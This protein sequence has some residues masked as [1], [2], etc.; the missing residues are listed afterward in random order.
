MT[1]AKW[2][3]LADKD[4]QS[5]K[6]MFDRELAEKKLKEAG[7]P[8]TMKTMQLGLDKNALKKEKPQEVTKKVTE[9]PKPKK[10]KNPYIYFLQ[11]EMSK[12][13]ESNN[14]QNPNT[15]VAAIGAKWREM[16]DEQK[17]PFIDLSK[18]DL[19]RFQKEMKEFD[20]T[21]FFTNAKGEYSKD[22]PVVKT[23]VAQNSKVK[24]SK[25]LKPEP[26]ISE[27]LEPVKPRKAMFPYLFYVKE[28]TSDTMKENKC[29]SASGAVK[30][31]SEQ[32]RKLTKEEKQPYIDK[33][34]KDQERHKKQMEEFKK[35]GQFTLE[36]GTSSQ[37]LKPKKKLGKL[38]KRSNKDRQNPDNEEEP[39]NQKVAKK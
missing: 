10:A 31:L 36:D 35:T 22:S 12:F 1:L 2:N 7:P 8:K 18:K 14:G 29:A 38:G 15:F 5:F 17:A 20:S 21:G 4:K 19:E 30:I 32:W 39:K 26:V 9:Y 11:A 24:N 3:E 28:N 25:P 23:V 33:S 27:K 13:K 16:T 37:S 34:V 6:N